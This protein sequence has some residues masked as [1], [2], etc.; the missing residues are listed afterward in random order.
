M[1]WPR[2]AASASATGSS[3]SS[4]SCYAFIATG[5][6]DEALAMFDEL[7]IDEWEQSRQAF[8]G[9]PLLQAT[10]GPI[11]AHRPTRARILDR[12][13]PMEASAD[14]Q[15]R[16]GYQCARARLLLA[17]GD[18]REALDLAEHALLRSHPDLGFAAELVKEAFVVAGEAA[19][20]LGDSAK[21]EPSCWPWWRRSLRDAP[22]GSYRAALRFRARLAGGDEP[23]VAERRI[24]RGCCALP[25]DR[26]PFYL[27]VVLLEH[28]EL[29]AASGRAEECE[30]LLAEAREIFERL[31]ATPWLERVDA[32]G[33]GAVTVA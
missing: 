10:S 22:R 6:W 11:A 14:V 25:R 4:A 26:L 31:R 15:E 8:A 18:P 5:E 12:F 3:A 16:A 20:A 21:L 29:L 28:A 2:A 23:T 19:L 27:A 13:Q 1:R 24:P 32:L 17:Q 7:P 9:G 33:V 30:P